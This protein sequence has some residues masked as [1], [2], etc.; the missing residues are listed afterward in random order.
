[1]RLGLRSWTALAWIGVTTAALF[2]AFVLPGPPPAKVK[3]LASTPN[4]VSVHPALHKGDSFP[5]TIELREGEFK[6]KLSRTGSYTRSRF[7]LITDV[8][9][10]EVSSY[11]ETSP[12]GSTIEMLDSLWRDDGRKVYLLRFVISVPGW[13]LRKAVH[14][15]IA[16]SFDDVPL[17]E[18]RIEIDGLLKAFASG[19]SAGDVFYLARSPGDRIHVGVRSEKNLDFVTSAPALTRAIW[20]MWA[21]PTAE[22]GRAGLVS[23]LQEKP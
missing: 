6:T 18:H 2:D 1:M 10:Y 17:D 8:D 16:R 7:V 4:V 15:E 11:V 20:R 13:Q 23:R 3:I 12:T 9:F 5:D 19:A 22:P 21:G 14:D